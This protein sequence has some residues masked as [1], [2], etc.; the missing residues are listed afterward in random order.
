MLYFEVCAVKGYF[1]RIWDRDN[2]VAA[3]I[4]YMRPVPS[5]FRRCVQMAYGSFQKKVILF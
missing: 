1:I 3:H 2:I 4:Q 5:I